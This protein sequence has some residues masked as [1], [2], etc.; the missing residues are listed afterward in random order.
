MVRKIICTVAM[1]ALICAVGTT[2]QAATHTVY[3]GE[4]PSDVITYCRDIISG[5]GLSDNYVVFRSGE[6]TFVMITG[7]LDFNEE[8]KTFTLSGDGHEY[9]FSRSGDPDDFYTYDN[10]YIE[11]FSVS[12]AD[13][14]LYSDLGYYPQLMER[15]AKYEILTTILLSVGLLGIVIGKFFCTR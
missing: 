6:H 1:L 7:S 2:A 11:D 12:A 15:G 5:I 8:T 10:G 3:P 9:I 13:S 4:L 14:V